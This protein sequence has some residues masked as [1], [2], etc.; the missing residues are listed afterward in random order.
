MSDLHKRPLLTLIFL[1]AMT[2]SAIA[3]PPSPPPPLDY[4]DTGAAEAGDGVLSFVNTSDPVQVSEDQT[5]LINTS[6]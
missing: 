1:V 3:Q 2:V 5:D 4:Y 6:G